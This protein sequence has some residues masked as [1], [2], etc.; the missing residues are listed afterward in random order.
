MLDIGSNMLCRRPY[1][2]GVR[3]YGCGS[4]MPCLIKR[5]KIWQHRIMLESLLHSDNCF[6]T[7]TYSDEEVPK[8]TGSSSLV[9]GSPMLTLEPMHLTNWLKRLR[10]AISPS[11]I[12]YYAVGEYGDRTWRPHYH[13]ALFGY[14]KCERGQSGYSASVKS[15]CPVCDLVRDTWNM[16]NVFLGD[17]SLQSAGYIARYVTKKMTR[18]DDVRL[19]GRWPEFARMSLCPGLGA[20]ALAPAADVIG[21]YYLEPTMVDVPH[22]LRHGARVLPLGRYLRDQ[23]RTRLG[24][25]KGAPPEVIKAWEDELRPVYEAAMADTTFTRNGDFKRLVYREAL[26]ALDAQKVKQIEARRAIFSEK[27]R[28]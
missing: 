23:L 21:R 6:V 25:E 14:P 17:L 28:L 3:A 15:C 7:L 1:T 24:R 13:V 12:R 18:N 10:K 27:E 16:G 4:C 5:R 19:D 2:Q 20:D 8:L 26:S 11:K 9:D 22:G